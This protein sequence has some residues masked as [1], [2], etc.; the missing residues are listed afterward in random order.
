MKNLISN[1]WLTSDTHYNHANICKATSKWDNISEDHLGVRDFNN[2]QS[3][4]D[5]IVNNI[6]KYVAYDNVLYHLGDWSFGGIESIFN[7]RKRIVCKTIHL[8]FGNHD[9]HIVNNRELPIEQ[10]SEAKEYMYNVH[11]IKYA[12]DML[13][14]TQDL[15]SSVQNVLQIKYQKSRHI[16]AVP[17]FLS[18]Y[19]HRVWDRHHKGWFHAFGHS[20]G[21]LDYLA[22]GRSIDVGIDTANKRFGEYRPYSADEFIEICKETDVHNIDHHNKK[23]N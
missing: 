23:T 4:N 11:N 9:H 5:D 19:S 15:F 18:H 21:S 16:K 17:I 13:V 8:I 22:N 7:F 10:Q 1:T 20:H 12:D 2:L 6:N 3:M 14:T